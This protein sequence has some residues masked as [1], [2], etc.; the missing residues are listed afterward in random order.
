MTH[1][2]NTISILVKIWPILVFLASVIAAL[3]AQEAAHGDFKKNIIDMCSSS[4]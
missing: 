1:K 4:V 3:A 2:L